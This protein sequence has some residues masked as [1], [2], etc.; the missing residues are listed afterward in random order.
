[1]LRPW[2]DLLK[3]LVTAADSVAQRTLPVCHF[4]DMTHYD[5]LYKLSAVTLLHTGLPE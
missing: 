2:L 5:S 4:R 1:M 3:I